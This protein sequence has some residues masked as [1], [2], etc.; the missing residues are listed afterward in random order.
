MV[1]TNSIT[2][3]TVNVMELDKLRQ[4]IIERLK[5][6]DDINYLNELRYLVWQMS[7]MPFDPDPTKL[8]P[9]QLRLI[10]EALEAVE[11]GE[12]FTLEEEIRDIDKWIEEN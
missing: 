10:K 12:F 1:K 7:Y 4:E 8:T 5:D 3:E 6:V 2:T 11:R 9:K